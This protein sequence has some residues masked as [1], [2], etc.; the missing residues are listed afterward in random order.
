KSPDAQDVAV[1]WLVNDREGPTRLVDVVAEGVSLS[2][3]QREEFAAMVDK[4]GGDI[5]AFIDDLD[6]L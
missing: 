3:S 1:E 2:I 5:D 4:R 6:K